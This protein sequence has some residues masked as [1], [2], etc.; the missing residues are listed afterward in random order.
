MAGN[1]FGRSLLLNN[2]KVKA[3]K[4]K[5]GDIFILIRG[6]LIGITSSN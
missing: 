4:N 1:I 5:K 6:D 3:I 2:T